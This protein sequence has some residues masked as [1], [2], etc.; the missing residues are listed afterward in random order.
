MNT[1]KIIFISVLASRSDNFI[2]GLTNVSPTVTAPTLWNYAVCG[3]YP[4]PVGAAAKVTVKWA[5]GLAAYRYLI[6]QFPITDSA[7]NFCELEVY[8]RRKLHLGYRRK[9][10][11]LNYNNLESVKY[12]FLVFLCY[13]N[14]LLS[15]R[16]ATE[17]DRL[18]SSKCL[19]ICLS[20]TKSWLSDT[21]ILQQTCLHR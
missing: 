3:Q 1:F 9:Y 17:Y 21:H 12:L 8:V 2:I 6:V 18:L 10:I 20:V 14:F 19:S 4:G 15:D 7:A 16:T 11:F 13:F 5:C